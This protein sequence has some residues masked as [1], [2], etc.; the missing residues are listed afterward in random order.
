MNSTVLFTCREDD[1][2]TILQPTHTL[3]V[4]A[5]S[6][7]RDGVKCTDTWSCSCVVAPTLLLHRVLLSN[8]LFPAPP[9]TA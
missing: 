1:H 3:R 8:R 5:Q 6:K 7:F 4:F 2:D 9:R